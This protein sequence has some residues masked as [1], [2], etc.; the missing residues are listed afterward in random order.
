[1]GLDWMIEHPRRLAKVTTAEVSAAA[2]EFF[3]PSRLV[4]V[5]VGDAASIAT[6]LQALT[7]VV[8]DGQPS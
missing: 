6:P 7:R 5:V 1:L 3:A 8:P 2:A 4:T